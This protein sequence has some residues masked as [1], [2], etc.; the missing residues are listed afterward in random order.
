MKRG[1]RTTS[2]L[3][4]LGVLASVLLFG[5][6]AL[7]A[8][9]RAGTLVENDV[10]VDYSVND[11]AQETLN[12]SADFLVDRRVNFQLT[13]TDTNLL[14]VTPG[15]PPATDPDYYVEFTLTNLS[16][17]LLDFALA[18]NQ[19]T[20]GVSFGIA[21]GGPNTDS[22]DFTTV[23][24][25]VSPDTVANGDPDPIRGG[26]Q[27]VDQLDADQSIRIWVF[28]DPD[29]GLANGLIA[30]VALTATGAEPGSAAATA[31]SEDA[32]T[33]LGVEN[34]FADADNDN[35]ETAEDGFQIVTADLDVSKVY[36]VVGGDLGSGLP[37]P[38][39]TIEYTISIE[40][41]SAATV[42]DDVT[43]IDTFDDTNT[44]LLADAYDLGGGAG[45][46]SQDIQITIGAGPATQCTA[47]VD[48][49]DCQVVG[50]TLTVGSGGTIDLAGT[51]TVTVQFRVV[52][53]DPVTTP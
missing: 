10:T 9:T 28:A 35:S 12:A 39:A 16:N 14:P 21:P 15:G 5:Q 32:N 43:V 47:A 38:G 18:L 4:R 13:V 45:D 20:T 41:L 48:A 33:D 31:L 37:I 44:A 53:A 24:Y 19:V 22:V 6:Q 36:S 52:I 29:V 25:A 17:D 26:D 51:T 8:G 34:V 23:D 27:F 40:N 11:V 50:D 30:G 1:M 46:G 49:D 3:A 2:L 42:A 7:A